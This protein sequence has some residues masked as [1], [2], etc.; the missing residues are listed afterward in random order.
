MYLHPDKN[1]PTGTYYINP[2]ANHYYQEGENV[3]QNVCF[4]GL[5]PQN[6][7]SLV[8]GSIT[9]ARVDKPY[10]FK[11]DV[12][13]VDENGRQIQGCFDGLDYSGDY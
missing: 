4:Y 2:N 6:I 13:V 8:S 10:K 3:Y 1:D 9:I 11:I 5:V 7:A 12:D